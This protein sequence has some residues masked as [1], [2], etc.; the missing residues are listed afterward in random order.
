MVLWD[1]AKSLMDPVV[2]SMHD[3]NMHTINS[4]TDTQAA[5]NLKHDVRLSYMCEWC[6]LL[7]CDPVC[8]LYGGAEACGWCVC[9]WC[10]SP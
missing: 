3:K 9:V 2:C 10:V 7:L 6:P 5:A 4:L 8:A 1:L